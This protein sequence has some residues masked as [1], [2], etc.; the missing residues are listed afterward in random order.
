M[1]TIVTGMIS[2]KKKEPVKEEPQPPITEEPTPEPEP[3][4]IRRRTVPFPENIV[5]NRNGIAAHLNTKIDFAMAGNATA[6]DQ[7]RDAGLRIVRYCIPWFDVE[8]TKGVYSFT[9]NQS[10]L[11]GYV[12]AQNAFVSRGYRPLIALA[13]S[14]T[15]YT[16]S[17]N[18][19]AKLTTTAALLGFENYCKAV[20]KQFR[21]DNPMFEIWNEPNL[22]SFGGWT[23]AEYMAL[24]NS[25]VRGVLGGWREGR[26]SPDLLDPIII[27]PAVSNGWAPGNFFDQCLNL[28]LQDKVDALSC[29]PYQNMSSKPLE[30]E[31]L[32][33]TMNNL[34]AEMERRGKPGMPLVITEWG[35]ST[36]TLP[37]EV[38]K[39]QQAKIAARQ[40]LVGYYL[41]LAV[42]CIY[43][44]EDARNDDDV[45]LNDKHYGM[46]STMGADFQKV[47]TAKPAVSSLTMLYNALSGYKYVERIDMGNTSPLNSAKDWCLVFWNPTTGAAKVAVWTTEQNITKTSPDLKPLMGLSQSVVVNFTDSPVYVSVS[48]YTPK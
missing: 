28:G 40:Q 1:V 29:H 44:F 24:V 39:A 7:S 25:A 5:P 23:A 11:P 16:G 13:F 3:E 6:M 37:Y 8:R 33:P 19:N 22:A 12:N 38:T 15:L 36:G 46:F 17:T 31:N 27:G 34:I 26:D 30:P 41:D 9:N 35:W 47:M 43:S 4:V 42:N 45:A 48:G 21:D 14:N 18:T 20:A 10:Y 2:C 32:V